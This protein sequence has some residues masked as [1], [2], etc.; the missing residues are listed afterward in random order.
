MTTSTMNALHTSLRAAPA[1]KIPA[2]VKSLATRPDMPADGSLFARTLE[3]V[4]H[5]A[6]AAV[7]FGAIA[8]MFL[9]H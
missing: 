9:A 3:V 6:L 4:S 5:A 8:W 2:S 7:P 1:F